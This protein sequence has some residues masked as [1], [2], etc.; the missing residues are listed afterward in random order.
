MQSQRGMSKMLPALSQTAMAF[1]MYIKA[2]YHWD[3]LHSLTRSPQAAPNLCK[4]LGYT[5]GEVACLDPVS[6]I[7]E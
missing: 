7:Q 4:E 5:R 2:A 3:R 6:S 1:D